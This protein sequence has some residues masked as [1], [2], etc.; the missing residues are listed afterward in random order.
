MLFNSY[1][2]ILAFL[3]ATL[4]IFLYLSREGK[5]HH[6]VT[7]LIFMSCLFYAW[8]SLKY[9]ILML[10]SILINYCLSVKIIKTR[11]SNR[12]SSKYFLWGGVAF[13]I[14][15]IVFFKYIDFIINCVNVFFRFQL[16][17]LGITL[18]LAISFFTFQQIA[19]LVD[20]YQ[21]KISAVDIKKYFLFIVFFPQ[22]I[23][24]P[25][26]HYNDIVYQFSK[27]TFGKNTKNI[28][29]GLTIFSLGLF[30]KVA[31][32]DTCAPIANSVFHLASIG[33]APTFWEA[34]I[35]AIFYSMQL[36]F[37]F[38]GYSDMAIG[39]AR[40]FGII[41]PINFNS[42]YKSKNIIDFWRRWHITL[43]EFLKNYIY[44]PM[45]GNRFGIL[46]Q[47]KNILITMLIGGVWHG[48]GFNFI[49]WGALHGFYLVI[50]HS[51]R[52]V[53]CVLLDNEWRD[54]KIYKYCSHFIT[55]ICVIVAWV[56]FRANEFST[57]IKMYS[58]MFFLE[59]IPLPT[60]LESFSFITQ[61]K[62]RFSF[63]SF[64]NVF[65]H[66]LF[67]IRDSIVLMLLL[68]IV[69]LA[70]PS[71]IDLMKNYR[72]VLSSKYF[73]NKNKLAFYWQPTQIWAFA[74]AIISI[75]SLCLL[76]KPSEF[77]YYKF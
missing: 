3:P 16:N 6:I 23:A 65:P 69:L 43:S 36:Y 33:E 68:I 54:S 48:A 72:P 37:D 2:F 17:T 64:G 11:E 39:L 10:A 52:R 77:L 49:L 21:S 4:I 45:G 9:L 76:S 25:I 70:F 46:N 30:K 57:A 1:P 8:W 73:I 38:S 32:A 44:V 50:N 34:W 24:G 42:P 18:P 40:L 56:L 53:A 20:A 7:W 55:L 41:L 22:L 60:R 66:Q 67:E 12:S 35:G 14:S 47:F 31:L 29:I 15:L 19:F 75:V 61:F 59:G 62:D 5:S 63:F 27:K 58:S 13:N 51:W 71:T 26:V 74:L 28:T